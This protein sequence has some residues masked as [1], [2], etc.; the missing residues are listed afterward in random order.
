MEMNIIDT[1]LY[2]SDICY[3][4]NEDTLKNE[5]LTRPESYILLSI[6]PGE[7]ITSNEL[8]ERNR[9]SPSRVSRIVDHMI[10]KDLLLR[11][12]VSDDRR[13]INLSLSKEGVKKHTEIMRLKN[14]CEKKIKSQLKDDELTA[15]KSGLTY[16]TK[17]MEK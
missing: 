15:V 5:N 1:V 3:S 8:A 13:F 12:E 14:Q 17:A 16:L 7:K 9:L 4:L 2:L 10:Q 6:K 11:T